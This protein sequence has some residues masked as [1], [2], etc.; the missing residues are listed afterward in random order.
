MGILNQLSSFLSGNAIPLN[1]KFDNALN[2]LIEDIRKSSSNYYYANPTLND[3]ESYSALKDLNTED[4]KELFF[5]VLDVFVHYRKKNT[6]K[7]SYSSDDLDRLKENTCSAILASFARSNMGFNDQEF[8]ETYRAFVDLDRKEIC[9]IVFVPI[10]LLTQQLTRHVKKNGLSPELKSFI[11]EALS[12]KEIAMRRSMF[13]TD[14]SK[15]KNKFETILLG[16]KGGAGA[17]PPYQFIEDQLGVQLNLEIKSMSAEDRKSYFK[18]FQNFA[19]SSGSKPSKKFLSDCGK[20]IDAIGQGKY[21]KRASSWIETIRSIREIETEHTNTYDDGTTYTWSSYVYLDDHSKTWVKGLVWSLVK[22]YDAHTISQ[23][24]SLS[25]TSFQKIPGVGARAAGIGNAC[26]YT[27][28]NSKG[29][30]GIGQLARL[31]LVVQQNN[32]KALIDK[33]LVQESEKRGI[34]Q[35][36][37]EELAVPDF[38]L[39][40]ECKIID[41]EEYQFKYQIDN[42]GKISQSW[43]KPDGTTQ[44]TA[45]TIVR[46]SAVLKKKLAKLKDEIK[47]VKKNLSAQRDRID[48]LFIREREWDLEDFQ[49]YYVNHGL[50]SFIARRL[51]WQFELNGNFVNV[52]Y[53]EDKWCRI[54]GSEVSITHCNKVRLWHPIYS[55]IDEL[56][57]WRNRLADL[58]INQPTKQ[59]YR[60]IY[61]LTDAEIN[62]KSYS[63]RMAAHI[64]KQHQFNALTSVRGWQYS[65]IGAFDYG[66][67]GTI[68]IKHLPEYEMTAQFWIEEINQEDAMTEAG[69]WTYISTD[70]VRFESLNSEV[71]NLIDVPKIVFSEVMRDVDLFVGVTSVGNDPEWR[72][73]GGLPQYRDYWTSYSFG[74]LNEVAKTRKSILE[75]LIPRLKIRDVAT[76]DGKF[77]RVKGKKRTYKIHIGSS[78]ILMEPNDQYLCIVPQRGKDKNTEGIFLPF[79]GDRGLSVVLS[80]AFLLAADEK[81]TDETILSQI[82]R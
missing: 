43:I 32:T 42:I 19:K 10:G 24:A 2:T 50:V 51:I 73:N 29:L 30:D 13:N 58:R 66:D 3:Y 81:I 38:G 21:K 36:E 70:Q 55:S 7:Q 44:K 41:F 16:E 4:K 1:D 12:W 60:E 23:I 39:H 65:L 6:K 20:L 76:I 47:Q 62:T 56:V 11:E 67:T 46:N 5:H 18:L 34:S 33:Y 72:D 14:L 78:N 71:I 40:D 45:P 69:I 15:I 52:V 25:E 75:G 79:E 27:L 64:L 37:I 8:I 31:K 53:T 80:K 28:A 59:A 26:L 74:D 77:L 17:V 82:N 49:K 63:N 68:A 35:A 54:D 57:S 61:L 22:F 48:R 9:S